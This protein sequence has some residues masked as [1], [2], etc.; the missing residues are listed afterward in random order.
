MYGNPTASNEGL[1][2]WTKVRLFPRIIAWS[3]MLFSLWDCNF[4]IHKWKVGTGRV[5]AWNKLGI[6]NSYTLESSFY[7]YSLSNNYE[8]TEFSLQNFFEIGESVAKSLL[9]YSKI[10]KD[11]YLELKMNGGWLK[12]IVLN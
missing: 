10:M 2:S 9:T 12:P 5:V 1:L 8:T 6:T 11:L 3:S 7:G 4:R